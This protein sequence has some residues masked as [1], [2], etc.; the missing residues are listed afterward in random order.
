VITQSAEK[1]VQFMAIALNHVVT[2]TVFGY[3]V[4]GLKL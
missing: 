1:V 2:L 3:K 4:L